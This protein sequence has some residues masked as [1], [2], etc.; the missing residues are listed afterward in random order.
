[1]QF[2]YAIPLAALLAAA[3]VMAT[4]KLSPPRPGTS[5]PP[6]SS[7][8]PSAPPA[9]MTIPDFAFVDQDNH[10]FSARDLRG[11]VWI[12]DFI[13]TGCANTCPAL[14]EKMSRLQKELPDPRIHFVSFDVDPD[15][16]TPA[17][18]R[19]YGEKYHAD[20]SRWHFL[21]SPSRAAAFAIAR[22]LHVTDQSD[23]RNFQLLHSDNFF[24]VDTDGKVGS[25]SDSNKSQ[26]LNDLRPEVMKLL[27]K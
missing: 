15:H 4:A 13:F 25:I 11:K 8:A 26:S 16:D 23:D 22:A 14:S 3:L 12:A 20:F 5:S 9:G 6:P 27:V 17:I 1:M 21:A 10:P 18:L 2:R 24:V 19:A 7:P